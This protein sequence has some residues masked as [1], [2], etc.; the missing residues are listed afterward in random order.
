MNAL[1]LAIFLGILVVLSIK[2]HRVRERMRIN[3][4]Y[5]HHDYSEKDTQISPYDLY[6]EMIKD[7]D[8]I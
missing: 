4:M 5:L 3:E 2:R 8:D 6:V 7:A 1:M